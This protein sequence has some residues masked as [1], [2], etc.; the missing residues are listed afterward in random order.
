MEQTGRKCEGERLLGGVE[1]PHCAVTKTA[2]AELG[3]VS[4]SEHHVMFKHRLLLVG[5]IFVVLGCSDSASG[6]AT[7]LVGVWQT[8]KESTPPG[9]YQRTLE[10]RADGRFTSEA[11]SFGMYVGQRPNDLSGYTRYTGHYAVMGDSLRFLDEQLVWWDR[12]YG[13]NS[14]EH[15]ESVKSDG[16]PGPAISYLLIGRTLIFH[17]LSYP[18]DGPVPTTEKLYRVR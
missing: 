9:S 10:L 12:F 1:G 5:A 2:P 4:P 15:V 17:Y 3:E 7:G 14:P 6:P 13:A 18:A 8:Q 16:P 11:R